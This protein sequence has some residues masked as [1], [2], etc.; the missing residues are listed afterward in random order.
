MQ[1]AAGSWSRGFASSSGGAGANGSSSEQL[2]LVPHADKRCKRVRLRPQLAC[3]LAPL[4]ALCGITDRAALAA[5][6]A[7]LG[8]KRKQGVVQHG[9]GVAAHLEQLG[10][11]QAQL[12]ALLQRC[13]LLFSWPVTERAAPRFGLLMGWLGLTATEAARCFVQKPTAAGSA[14]FE[15]AIEALA[16]LFAAASREQ[17]GSAEAAFSEAEWQAGKRQLG[18]L[19][20]GSPAAVGLLYR[21]AATLRQR[22]AALRERYGLSAKQLVSS[23]KQYPSLLTRDPDVHLAA[24]EAALEEELGVGGRALVGAMLRATPRAIG[25]GVDTFRQR[26]RAPVKVC[27]LFVAWLGGMPGCWAARQPAWSLLCTRGHR[28]PPGCR[29][30]AFL[31]AQ[32]FTWQRLQGLGLGPLAYLLNASTATWQ[33]A[34]AVWRALGVADP[35]ALAL[36]NTRPLTRDW[37]APGRLANLL[38][39]QRALGLSSPGAV[40][41]QGLAGYVACYAPERVA[42]RL[43]LLEQAGRLPLLVADKEQWRTERGLPPRK[44]S[45]GEPPLI[46]LSDVATL[47]DDARPGSR[48]VTFATAA[49]VSQAALDAFMAGLPSHPPYQQLL[50][51]AAALRARLLRDPEVA[52]LAAERAGV[53]AE[54]EST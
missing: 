46:S 29:L 17:A 30:P 26:C 20:R 13:P 54:E 21:D 39:L 36:D 50:A 9:A 48:T 34:L 22:C 1:A 28:P 7:A 18:Q 11:T 4:A 45:P 6:V 2:V 31:A 44:R 24:V 51:G 3:D 35:A 33:L 14:S 49:G 12:G 41:E 5:A 37:L 27:V 8:P 32:A 10:L 42:S 19:L 15:Q 23:L 53:P 16:E 38:A 52:R 40:V 47:P 25:C 43:L